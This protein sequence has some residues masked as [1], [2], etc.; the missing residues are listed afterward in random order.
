MG[1]LAWCALIKRL[2][3]N[4]SYPPKF[5][6]LLHP[7][8]SDAYEPSSPPSVRVEAAKKL[9]RFSRDSFSG[10]SCVWIKPDD[11]GRKDLA[12]SAQHA[13]LP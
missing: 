1:A 6:R 12:G 13:L 11:T 10:V 5:T 4:E 7:R 8:C 2:N 3:F 9:F